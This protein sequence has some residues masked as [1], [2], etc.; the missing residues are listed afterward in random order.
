MKT[1]TR[2]GLRGSRMNT[3]FPT[4][5]KVVPVAALV[6]SIGATALSF[7]PVAASVA[8]TRQAGADASGTAVAISQGTFAQGVPVVYIAASGD[9]PYVLPASAASGALR[10]PVLITTK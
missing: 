3:G 9:V 4:A 6:L 10:G 1:L 2:F 8:V 5:T 7:S